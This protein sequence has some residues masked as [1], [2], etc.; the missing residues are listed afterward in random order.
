MYEY[1]FIAKGTQD[2]HIL[3]QIIQYGSDM[4]L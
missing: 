4:M 3:S 2:L 1:I